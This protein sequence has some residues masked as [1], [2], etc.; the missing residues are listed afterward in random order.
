MSLPAKGSKEWSE[1][2]TGKKTFTF[3]FLATKI[4][5]GRL[6]RSV[7]EN[8]SPENIRAGIDQLYDVFAKN[9]HIPSVQEDLKTIFG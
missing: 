3:K 5:L 2:V 9:A 7:S 1:I 6:T 4:L 8:P